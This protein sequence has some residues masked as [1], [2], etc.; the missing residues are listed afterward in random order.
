[1]LNLESNPNKREKLPD[2]TGAVDAQAT[3]KVK[4]T[5]KRETLGANIN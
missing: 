1:M 3:S 4:T 2:K 5:F